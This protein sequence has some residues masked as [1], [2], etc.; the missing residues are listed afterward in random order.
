Y[1][2][3]PDKKLDINTGLKELNVQETP[4]SQAQD[5][6][7]NY[8]KFGLGNFNTILGEGY[9]SY[10]EYENMQVGGFLKHLSQKGSLE[11]QKFSRQGVGVLGS[12]MLSLFTVDGLSS[13]NRYATAFCGIPLAD[14]GLSSLSP[15]PESQAFHAIYFTGELTSTSDP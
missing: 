9:F 13:Y 10:D 3:I 6:R 15:S 5:V 11:G 2:N 8:V 1:G 4:F 12:R 7:S 14:D